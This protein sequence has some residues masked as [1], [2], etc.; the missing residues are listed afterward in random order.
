MKLYHKILLALLCVKLTTIIVSY[1]TSPYSY[2]RRNPVLNNPPNQR[3]IKYKSQFMRGEPFINTQ[4]T[5]CFSCEKEVSDKNKYLTS[6]SKCFSCE[7]QLSDYHG[8]KS[9]HLAQPTKCFS[10]E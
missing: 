3:D 4:P 10:C 5:K 9:A 1:I 2:G 8:T 7:K 6:P